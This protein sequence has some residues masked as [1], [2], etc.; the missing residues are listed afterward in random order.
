MLAGVELTEDFSILAQQFR[1]LAH[2][3]VEVVDLPAVPAEA[4]ATRDRHFRGF[5]ASRLYVVRSGSVTVRYQDRTVFVLEEGDI[6][7]PDITGNAETAATVFYGS[8]TGARL[9]G[10]PA[11]EFM[12]RV[13]EDRS[14]IKLWTRLLITYAG[15]MTRLAAARTEEDTQATP[16]FEVYQPGATIIGQ[17]ERADYVYSL[18]EGA[19]EVIV[20]GVVVGRV[21]P[22][23]IFGAMAALTNSDRSATV[24]ARAPC[25]VI[26]VPKEQ[27]TDLIKRNPTMIH[28][29]LVD[30]ANSSVNLNEQRVGLRGRD[31]N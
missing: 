30:M 6:L 24:V 9:D 26:K 2:A 31:Q 1:K 16:G 19:A 11:L 20:D 15:L 23:E 14:A 12:R 22:G 7:L 3:L 4:V 5:D 27:F 10:Y 29:L 25:S 13:F 17:G 28:G 8:D 18:S 21:E